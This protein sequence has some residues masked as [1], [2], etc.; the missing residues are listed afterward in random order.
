MVGDT[1]FLTVQIVQLV[2]AASKALPAGRGACDRLRPTIDP[3]VTRTRR[4]RERV[5]SQGGRQD[6]ARAGFQGTRGQAAR[7][8]VAWHAVLSGGGARIAA[9]TW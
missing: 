7:G 8:S 4:L 5:A 9:D 2:P 6:G 3:A 1:V